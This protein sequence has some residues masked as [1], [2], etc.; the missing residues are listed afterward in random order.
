MHG[1]KKGGMRRLAEA[2]LTTHELM[3]ISGHRTLSEVQRYTEDAN[4]K[5]LA[6][7]GMAKL[8]GQ[9][10]NISLANL[11]ARS[12]KPDANPLKQKDR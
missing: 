6:D 8:R 1:L 4:R 3:A 11:H 2:R 5:L 7:T 10:E 12:G 9:S